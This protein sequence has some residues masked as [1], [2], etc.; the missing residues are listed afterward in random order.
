MKSTFTAPA[1]ILPCTTLARERGLTNK[2]SAVL[3]RS[4]LERSVAPSRDACVNVI[5]HSQKNM[6]T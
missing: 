5:R 6:H 3:S 4:S 2:N 1:S